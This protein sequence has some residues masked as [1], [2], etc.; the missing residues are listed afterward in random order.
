MRFTLMLGAPVRMRDGDFG[1]LNRIIVNNGVANQFTVDPG[2]LFSGPD[3][4]VPISDVAEATEEGVLLNAS[5]SEWKSYNAFHVEQFMVDN[6][7][8][9]PDLSPVAP[10]LPTTDE[11][12]DVPTTEGP[13]E[14]RI[15]TAGAVALSNKTRVGDLGRLAGMVINTGNGCAFRAGRRAGRRTYH[16]GQGRWPARRRNRARRQR[17]GK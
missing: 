15:A 3:R 7:A 10:R 6:A 13:T 9:A 17:A 4:V 14:D 5:E 16:A 12:W 2:G 1:A 11:M 8:S